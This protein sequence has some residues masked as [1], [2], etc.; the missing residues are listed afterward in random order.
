MARKKNYQTENV[1]KY[2]DTPTGSLESSDYSATFLRLLQIRGIQNPAEIDDYVDPKFEKLSDPTE[3]PGME[4]AVVRIL[5]AIENEERIAIYGD[6]DV[7]GVTATAVLSDFFESIGVETTHYIPSRVDEGY[8]LNNEAIKQLKKQGISLIVTVDCGSTSMDEVIYAS[9]IGVDIVVTDHHSLK[10][11]ENGEVLLPA[12]IAVVNPKR[13]PSDSPLYELAG[14]AVAFYLARALQRHFLDKLPSG[15]EKWLLDLVALGTICDI[16]PLTGE[17]RI[18]ANYGLRVIRR[19]R[20]LGIIALSAVAEFETKMIDSYRVGFLLGPRLNASGRMEHAIASLDLLLAKDKEIAQKLAHDLNELNLERQEIT[21][22]IVSE[23]RELILS[24][25]RKQ[26]IYLLSHEAWPAG[27]VGI[28]ASRLVD[29]FRRPMLIAED[30]GG[31]L[32]GSARSVPGFNIVEAMASIGGHFERFGGHA[33]A[34]G[35]SLDKEKFVL[36]NDALI[37]IAKDRIDVENLKPVVEVDTEITNNEITQEFV[38]NLGLLEPYGRDNHK[39]VFVITGAK[40][41]NYKLVGSPAVHLKLTLEQGGVNISGIAFSYGE[42]ANFEENKLYDFAVTL[43]IN[44]WNN[45]K[46]PE[47]RVVDLREYH[48]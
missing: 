42:V 25:D 48:A 38:S 17:N 37:K 36:V 29:E 41:V 33:Y 21:E 14:V 27:V 44:E 15:Q 7:D 6:Y 47:F 19:T 40:I 32:K 3:I 35:F 16:V 11:D 39:P 28:V 13:L 4:A 9:S 24:S 23:A 10:K 12:A 18:L 22:R 45:R 43:E 26:L 8:G 1:W 31:Y 30:Q 5:K 20:R 46:T 2:A 34:A